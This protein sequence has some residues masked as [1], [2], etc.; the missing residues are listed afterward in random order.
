M[1]T[2]VASNFIR[3]CRRRSSATGAGSGA[4]VIFRFTSCSLAGQEA[5][6]NRPEVREAQATVLA[7]KNTGMAVTTDIGEAKNVH[8]KNKQDVGDRLSRIALANVYG[9][10][11]EFSGPVYESMNIE[12]GAIR[13]KF[14]H[15]GGG[16]VAARR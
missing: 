11:I 15:P 10:K 4:K 5:A 16:L 12:G 9:R 8:P 14:S 3:T 13:V 6:S 1:R 2:R 7:L